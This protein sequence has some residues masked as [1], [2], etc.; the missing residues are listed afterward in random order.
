MAK[1]KSPKKQSTPNPTSVKKSLVPDLIIESGFWKKN[2]IPALILFVLSIGLYLQTRTFDYVLDDKIVYHENGLVKK[3]FGG[4]AEIFGT[5]SMVGYF[6]EQINLLPGS[7]YRPLSIATFAI[8]HE[9]IGNQSYKIENYWIKEFNQNPALA[10]KVEKI[11]GDGVIYEVIF[12]TEESFLT[13]LTAHFSESEIAQNKDQFLFH[14]AYS[15]SGVSHLINVLLY[16]LLVLLLFRLLSV[17]FPAVQSKWYLTMAFISTL[18]FVLHPI[19][20]EA[21]ANVKGR[22][23]ILALTGALAALFFTLKYIAS[24]KPIHLVLSGIIFLFGLL[25]KEH[26]LTFI[27]LIPLTTYFFTNSSFKKNAI[28]IVPLAIASLIFLYMRNEAIGGD[29][30]FNL[31]GGSASK[32]LMNNPFVE[33]S[34][35]EALATKFYTLGLYVK[36][37]LF[38]HPLTHDY[39]PYHIPIMTWGNISTIISFLLYVGMG[40]FT[41]LGLRKKSIPAYGIFFFL[42]PLFAVSNLVVSVGTFMNDRFVFFSSVGFCIILGYLIARKLP[43]PIFNLGLLGILVLGYFAKTITRTADWKNS[44]TLNVSAVMNSPNSARAN[45]YMSTALFKKYAQRETDREKKKALLQEVKFYVDRSLD[46]HPS[47]GSGIKMQVKVATDIYRLDSKIEPLLQTFESI[48]KMQKTNESVDIYLNHFKSNNS[49]INELAAFSYKIGYQYF[50][51]QLGDRSTA[52]KYINYGLSIAPSDPSLQQAA[53]E[54][55]GQ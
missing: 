30:M 32:D 10:R 46:I 36:L 45:L 42:I 37:L 13:A 5:E 18:L 51:K 31:S 7:R 49:W 39:Y 9:F 26:V 27:A 20:V 8:E 41:V 40:V 44:Y 19:H 14:A 55:R 33:M 12:P 21:V 53:A 52:A 34:S 6:G 43:S 16:G 50:F 35:A 24:E 1:K 23:E 17:L 11:I 25:A 38:P 3:G 47:Y 22:D 4:I 29:N 2:A 48:I 54:L 15:N 28:S